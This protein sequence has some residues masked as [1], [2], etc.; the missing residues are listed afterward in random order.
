M[1]DMKKFKI[2][3]LSE[4]MILLMKKRV[5]DLCGCLGEH[6]KIH[7]NGEELNVKGF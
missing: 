3:E 2:K 1:P 7:L 4:E 6:V 5:Y